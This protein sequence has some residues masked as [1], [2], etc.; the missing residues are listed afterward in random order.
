[1]LPLNV[2]P[3]PSIVDGNS[4]LILHELLGGRYTAKIDNRRP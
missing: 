1:M 2:Y 4:S 3:N